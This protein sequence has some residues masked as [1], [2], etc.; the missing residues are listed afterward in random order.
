MRMVLISALEV[1]G[2]LVDGVDSDLPA[3]FG[4]RL[5]LGFAQRRGRLLVDVGTSVIADLIRSEPTNGYGK[6]GSEEIT[7]SHDHNSQSPSQISASHLLILSHLIFIR[8]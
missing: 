6:V 1:R 8:I 5:T 4:R 3:A 7:T 2:C